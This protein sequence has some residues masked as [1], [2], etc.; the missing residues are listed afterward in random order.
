MND[1]LSSYLLLAYYYVIFLLLGKNIFPIG[2]IKHAH[3][4]KV[5][6]R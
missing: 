1:K 3:Y 5:L 4:T 6:R 2:K